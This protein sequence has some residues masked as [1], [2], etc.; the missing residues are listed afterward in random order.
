MLISE[1]GFTFTY[2]RQSCRN[3]RKIKETWVNIFQTLFFPFAAKIIHSPHK[4]TSTVFE[5]SLISP[6]FLK[7]SLVFSNL[8]CFPLHLY[9]AH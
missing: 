8:Y 4:L 5:V 7:R 3:W 9:I 6:V 1:S 2:L